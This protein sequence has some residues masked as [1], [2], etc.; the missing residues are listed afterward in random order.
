MPSTGVQR[1]VRPSGD[2]LTGNFDVVGKCEHEE[3]VSESAWGPE[4]RVF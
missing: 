2:T 1:R 3:G 4:G